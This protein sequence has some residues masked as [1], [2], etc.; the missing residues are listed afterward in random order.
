MK[1]SIKRSRIHNGDQT[2]SE[3]LYKQDHEE[4]DKHIFV[5]VDAFAPEFG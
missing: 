2:R 3:L 4:T 5:R 1:V